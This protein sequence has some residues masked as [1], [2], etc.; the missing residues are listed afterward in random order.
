MMIY[1]SCAKTMAAQSKVQVPF[2]S[3]PVFE[4]EAQQHAMDMAQFTAE[5]L[6]RILRINPKLAAENYLRYHDFLST[7][8]TAVPAILSYTGIVFKRINPKDFTADDFAYAQQHLFITSFLYGLLRPLDKIKNYRMEGDV[9]LP[10][11]GNVTMFDYWKPVLTDYF[12]N[13]IKKQEG[14]LVNLASDEMKDLF[15]WKRVCKEVKV[16]NPEFMVRKNGKLK[17]VVIYAKMCRG[18]MTRFILKNRIEDTESLKSFEWEGFSFDAAE[19]NVN[20]WV[21]TL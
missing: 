5:E 16:I 14:I 17:T 13:E 20:R 2:T 21:F 10:E 6:G 18:E 11:R 9:R 4:N 7:D 15:D 19:S 8:N 3:T 1:I 12:I